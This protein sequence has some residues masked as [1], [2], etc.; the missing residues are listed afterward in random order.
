MNKVSIKINKNY[1]ESMNDEDEELLSKE[2]LE[3]GEPVIEN[4][5]WAENN[6]NKMKK[7]YVKYPFPDWKKI[8]KELNLKLESIDEKSIYEK[9]VNAVLEKEVFK[10]FG[11]VKKEDG[12]LIFKDYLNEKKIEIKNRKIKESISKISPDFLVKDIQKEKFLKMMEQRCYMF[13]YRQVLEKINEKIT[14]INLIGE[15]KLNPSNIK[16][17]QRLRYVNFCDYMNNLQNTTEFYLTVYIFNSSYSKLWNKNFQM[18]LP[19]ILSY[20]PKL[21]YDKYYKVYDNILSGS[22]NQIGEITSNEDKNLESG[23]GEEIFINKDSNED[24]DNKNNIISVKI[25]NRLAN[26]INKK[27]I[28]EKDVKREENISKS[29]LE[30]YNIISKYRTQEDKIIK[31]ERDF[32]DEKEEM[33]KQYNELKEEKEKELRA[34]DEKNKKEL[35]KKR[36]D[37]E[38]KKLK[39]ERKIQ[40]EKKILENLKMILNRKIKRDNDN[41]I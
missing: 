28:D 1:K 26:N 5:N 11:F 32:E 31:F 18:G 23:D 9:V 29:E 24:N 14:K 38:D 41:I 33:D 8:V 37:N 20:I 13:R 21:Y 34:L 16:K 35:K 22:N 2:S 39:I 27:F 36:W 3:S 6:Y 12:K 17:D 7:Y 40:D 10:E 19:I 15:I 30:E 4:F 25:E